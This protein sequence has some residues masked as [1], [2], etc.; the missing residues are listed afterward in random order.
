MLW[1]NIANCKQSFEH[2]DKAA[3]NARD[4]ES[5]FEEA[6]EKESNITIHV[7]CH[8]SSRGIFGG[9]VII[10]VLIVTIILFFVASS[11]E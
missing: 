5:D 4:C 10:I 2:N 1:S 3:E 11:D 9:I 8:S 6:P 7:D